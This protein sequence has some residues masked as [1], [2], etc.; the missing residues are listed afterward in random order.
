MANRMKLSSETLPGGDEPQK[1]NDSGRFRD[2]VRVLSL[3]VRPYVPILGLLGLMSLVP[4]CIMGLRP[5]VLAP[6]LGAVLSSTATP[7]EGF[8]DLTLDN[9]GVTLQQWVA[10]A[11]SM[12]GGIIAVCALTYVFLTLIAAVLLATVQT[13]TLAV[14]L[15]LYRDMIGGLHH[16]VLR[17]SLTFFRNAK[18]GE[19]VSRFAND[20]NKVSVS[21]DAIAMGAIQCVT[22]ITVG[23][24]ILFRTNV[25]L[26]ILILLVGSI[27]FVL[28]HFLGDWVR[29]RTRAAFG[30]RAT[31]SA[32][33]FESF[34]SILVIKS[35]AAERYGEKRVTAAAED[36]R[37]KVFRSSFCTYI[38]DP[39]RI[40]TDGILTAFIL[41]I[42]R[43]ALEHEL[44]TLPGMVLFF[45]M[46]SQMVLP[47]SRLGQLIVRMKSLQ[48]G[49][50]RI[51]DVLSIKAQIPDGEQEAQ[52]FNKSLVFESV[53]FRHDETP[54]LDNVSLS[55]RK[56]ET[57]AVVGPSGGGK[58]TLLNMVLRFHDPDHGC[59]QLDGVDIR[60][61]TRASYRSLFG[62]VPQDAFLFNDTIKENILLGRPFE[63]AQL[64]HACEVA[65]L[66]GMLNEM[67]AG[68]NTQVGDRGERLSGGQRQRVSLA[69]AIYGRPNVLVLD[70]ATSA[71]DAESEVAIQK[72]MDVALASM[73][74]IVVAH[75][76][77]TVVNADRIVVLDKGK[78]LSVGTHAELL[79]E[80]SVYRRLCTLQ[81]G[82]SQNVLQGDGHGDDLTVGDL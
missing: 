73:T 66:T 2:I 80:S 10:N 21:L 49:A 34:Q 27:H 9:V 57:V 35:F 17:L 50:S 26:T 13:S 31:F 39:A 24:L 19:L 8:A 48:G 3:F 69:R 46:A 29:V 63:A 15:R 20:L 77:S 78:I 64:T 38:E 14:R 47:M 67:P 36:L 41:L 52:G 30:A 25:R 60:S 81:F 22:Q 68:L 28:T 72:A 55:I 43:Y 59:I 76:L 70:E 82:G 6:A 40:L 12:P 74:G 71:L 61:F 53:G 51:V 75:R 58:T 4:G 16:H 37:H 7:A 62:V 5:L 18:T 65:N 11:D 32:A 79:K 44:L 23:A 45:Y 56:G 1:S 54:V 42:C 33:L